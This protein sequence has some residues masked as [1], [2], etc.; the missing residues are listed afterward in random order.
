MPPASPAGG[1]ERPLIGTLR[2]F[3]PYLWPPGEPMLKARIVGAL[4]FVLLSKIVQVYGAPF[5]LQ[6]AVDRMASGPRDAV[7]LVVLLVIGY[8]AARFGTIV[9]DNLRN[10]IF[11]RVGQDAT[12]RLAAA[13]FR[14]L[15]DL[16]LRFH[17]ERRTGAV[18][19]VVERGTKS[20]DTMLYFLLF[21]IA[22]T[23][24]ELGLVLQIFAS[25]F[26]WWLVAGTLVM[27]ALYIVFTR[28]VTDWR[29]K[30]RETMNDLDTGAVAHAVDSLLNFETVK[31][32]NAEDREARRYE[33]A[34]AAYA[35][36]AVKS[37]NSLA[38]LNIGQAFITNA[39][40]AGGMA[41]VAYGW[42]RGEFSPGEVVLVSTLL[43]QLFRP[44]DLLGM[45]YRTIRQGVIDMGAMFDL[46]DTP[47]E[48]V[49]APGAPPLTVMQGH[50][51][52]EDVRFGYDDDRLILK[53]IDLDIP[54]GATV[55]VVGPS[56]AGK[57]T[58]A[59]LLYRFYDL[60]G[61]RITIDDQDIALVTQRS[62]RAAIGIVPQDTVLFNDT[63]G[64]NIAYG[65]EGAGES[66]IQAAARGAAIAGFIE[67]LPD[68]YETRVGERGL[69]LSG[70]EK[71]RVAIARTLVKDPP[72]L[73]LDEAT[74]ALDS[75]T[76]AEI[77]ATL[78]DIE[79]GRTTIVIAHRLSTVVHADQ[80]VVL[81]AGRVAERGT[82]AELLRRNGLY[83]EMWARQA[84]EQ[85][86]AIAAE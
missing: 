38:W 37:E 4:V 61:G 41:L 34:V 59:R 26:G 3:L 84:A 85:E 63:I 28:V 83:A 18:T 14:H 25:R 9:F 65:R 50:V 10:A 68:G 62:L 70:G 76:E 45:V 29:A 19:K 20:I 27:V 64:Y 39:M 5:A 54:A 58:L 32:F 79:A 51:R 78:E 21:N 77:Q 35:N 1:A 69:K 30:L 53:G 82:H 44:L 43:S 81:E 72:I 48:V 47:S 33:R 46:I 8:A 75:R 56:G 2:R 22:P 52:F 74:S 13:V 23:V 31:Y 73:I 49:D 60:T 55:A 67:G 57:S 71:Q 6:G 66:E 7:T 40:L 36:A 42:A 15:H 11:E 80:I 16:S 12:R 24:L 17:L 86:A